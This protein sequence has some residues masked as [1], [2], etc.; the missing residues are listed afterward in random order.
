MN[1]NNFLIDAAL[2]LGVIQK[3]DAQ[4][5]FISYGIDMNSLK[6]INTNTGNEVVV[7]DTIFSRAKY[8]SKLHEIRLI[9]NDLISQTDWVF[10]EDSGVSAENKLKWKDYRIKLRDCT[11]SLVEG[12]EEEFTF[13]KNPFIKYY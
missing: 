12:K 5:K 6:I 7:D 9:R 13:P 3:E 1:A 8:M 10:L 2:D 11:D 4:G